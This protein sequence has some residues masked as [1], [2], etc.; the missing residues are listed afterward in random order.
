MTL[1]VFNIEKGH[2]YFLETLKGFNFEKWLHHI[3]INLQVF[4]NSYSVEC[5][6]TTVSEGHLS[7]HIFISQLN[8]LWV[9]N[10]ISL[11]IYF[12]FGTKFFWNEGINICFN[13]ECLLLGHDFDFLGGYLVVTTCYLMVTTGYCSFPGGYCSLWWLLLVTACFCLFPLLVQTVQIG[14]NKAWPILEQAWISRSADI[15]AKNIFNPFYGS[16]VF[17]CCHQKTRGFLMFSGDVE[18]DQCH[19]M[20]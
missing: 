13:V 9:P 6:W 18:G 14:C 8:L 19:E 2:H 5:W 17:L 15:F 10:F 12:P 7:C 11:G 16:G 4:Q 1:K 3:L 20:G